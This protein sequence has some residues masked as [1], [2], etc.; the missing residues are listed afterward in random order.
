M[1]N[2]DLRSNDNP[3]EANLGKF[4]RKEGSYLG[5]NHVDKLKSEG[6]KK[7]RVFLALKERIPLWGYETI[8]RDDSTVGFLRRAEYAYFLKSSIG[9][10]YAFNIILKTVELAVSIFLQLCFPPRRI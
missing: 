8:W 9:I 4:C 7:R 10:G 6:I 3:V 1:W 5:K 2:Y